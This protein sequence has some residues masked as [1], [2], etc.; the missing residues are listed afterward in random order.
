VQHSRLRW[1]SALSLAALASAASPA[2]GVRPVAARQQV[3]RASAA[4]L[5]YVTAQINHYRGL[6]RFVA[7]GP[8]YNAR[9][10]VKG[11]SLF[12]IPASSTIPFVQTIS[13]NM[14]GIAQTMGLRYIEWPNQGQPSQW[15]QGMDSAT[16][17]GVSAVDLLAGVNPATLEPQIKA[18]RGAGVATIVSHLYNVGQTPVP[19]LAA[20]VDIPYEKAGRLLS[21]WTIAKTGGH[22][23]AVVVTINEVVS[24]QAMVHGITDEAAH[25]CGGGCKL[26]FINVTI[27][28]VATKIQPE[29]QTALA[30][31]PNI[32]YVI[33]LYD[34]AEAPFAVAGIR[35]AGALGRVKVV[36]F[37]GTPSVLKMVQD[38][39]GVEMDIGENLDWIARAIVDQH[40]RLMAGLPALHDPRIPLRIFDQKTVGDTGRPPR[41]STGFGSSYIGGYNTLWGLSH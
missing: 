13:N 37:N 15:V 38:G 20:T 4:D 18:A 2:L 3:F 10:A 41:D 34:S 30:Q 26:S 27:P 8:A 16:S 35:A 39:A 14:G 23:D 17:R 12:V 40:M 1:L 33:A 21:D 31:D 11:K 24:T 36:T 19:N 29:V 6:P 9:K 32:N 7:P 22:V 25:H 5:S 28:E